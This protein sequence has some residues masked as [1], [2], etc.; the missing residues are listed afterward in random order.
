MKK[1]NFQSVIFAIMFV[2]VNG[3]KYILFKTIFNHVQTK[4]KGEINTAF[5]KNQ[6]MTKNMKNT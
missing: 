6:Q 4:G 5:R 2:T 3:N 1:S